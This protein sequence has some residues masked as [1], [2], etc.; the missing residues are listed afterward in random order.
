MLVL[1][2]QAIEGEINAGLTAISHGRMESNPIV[3]FRPPRTAAATKAS[4]A[5]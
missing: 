5:S 2:D 1:W 4:G 3:A